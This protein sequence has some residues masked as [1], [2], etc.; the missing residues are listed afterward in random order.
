MS[1]IDITDKNDYITYTPEKKIIDN[2]GNIPENLMWSSSRNEQKIGRFVSRFIID[3]PNKVEE[4]VNK[5]KSEI[6]ALNN[7]DNFDIVNGDKISKFYHESSYSKGGGSL[8]KSCM[9]HDKCQDFFTF[10]NVN[11]DKVNLVVLYE[12][13]KRKYILGRALLW[14]IDDPKIQLMDRIYTTKD[15]DQNLFIKLAKK[16]GWYYKKSQ[17]FDTTSICDNKGNEVQ[18]KA[19]IYLRKEKHRY[20]P[21]LDTFYFYDKVNGY[22][23]NDVEEYKN[24]KNII[25][26]R[27]TDGGDKGNENFVFDIYNNDFIKTTE[28]V[29][30]Y[31]GNIVFAWDAI[32]VNGYYTNPNNVRLSEYD[33]KIYFKDDAVWSTTHKTFINFKKSFKVFVDEKG[34]YDYIHSDLKG[35]TFDYVHDGDSYFIKELLVKGID[36]K[37]YLKTRYNEDEVKKK[38]SVRNRFDEASDLNI[39][40]DEFIKKISSKEKFDMEYGTFGSTINYSSTSTR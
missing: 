38:M 2:T 25:R 15:S 22:L 14:N 11:P 5:F 6:V 33:G 31:N 17:G 40:F 27:S 7:L 1:Y 34:R 12:D 18:F 23:T 29:G 30:D 19:K 13:S 20:F 32:K 37:Y 10:Y 36:N 16:R 39:Y 28:A 3:D 9:R 26:L 4:F 35:E 24:N 21:Y 8:N